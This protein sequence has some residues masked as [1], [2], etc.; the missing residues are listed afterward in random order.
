VIDHQPGD[1]TVTAAAG[2]TLATLESALA[3]HGQWLPIDPPM[4]ETTTVGGLVAANLSGPL[5]G[6]AG[7]GARSPPRGRVVDATGAL[8]RGG[9]RVVKNVAGYDLPKLY[10]GALGSLGVLTAATFKVAR[11]RRSSGR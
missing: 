4:A 8:V 7:H 9:G 1:M 5:R 2:C 3:R 11:V 6:L 10:V